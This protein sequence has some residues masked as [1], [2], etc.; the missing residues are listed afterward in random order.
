MTAAY[1]QSLNNGKYVNDP[2]AKSLIE[3]HEILR[4][5]N[6]QLEI[7]LEEAQAIIDGLSE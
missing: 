1:V 5:Q 7:A 2:V 4:A 3:S 6:K